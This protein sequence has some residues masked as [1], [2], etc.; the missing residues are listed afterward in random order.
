MVFFAAMSLAILQGHSR[1]VIGIFL[2]SI[3]SQ[4][5]NFRCGN[6]GAPARNFPRYFDIWNPKRF[7]EFLLRPFANKKAPSKKK[8][9]SATSKK[10]IERSKTCF[11]NDLFYCEGIPGWSA[12]GLRSHR[13]P[14]GAGQGP[15]PGPFLEKS[16][17]G[18]GRWYPRFVWEHCLSG[19]RSGMVNVST[20]ESCYIH[21]E[22]GSSDC[23]F[24]GGELPHFPTSTTDPAS[25][26][27]WSQCIHPT[28]R[29]LYR[30][31]WGIKGSMQGCGGGITQFRLSSQW[32][33]FAC[34][35]A[36]ASCYEM[37]SSGMLKKPTT[38][39]LQAC[40]RI[41]PPHGVDFI[42]EQG[43]GLNAAVCPKR[44]R[45]EQRHHSINQY[46]ETNDTE[47]HNLGFASVRTPQ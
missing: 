38:E 11:T 27:A 19:I 16:F 22:W 39:V 21:G 29:P 3:H 45:A 17:K 33:F 26:P 42:F 46:Q 34:R 35:G 25:Q 10:C 12:C 4:I 6:F 9:E 41:R 44:T 30:C 40:F 8:V 7:V 28:L 2:A 1:F 18:G 47:L 32:S 31:P 13:P 24:Q 37:P 15:W 36:G 20:S 14:W 5:S 43:P 23:P